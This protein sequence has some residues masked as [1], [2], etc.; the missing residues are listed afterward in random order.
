MTTRR[1]F[2]K[3]SALAMAGSLAA[4][5]LLL[6]LPKDLR[7]GGH[8]GVRIDLPEWPYGD[9][10]TATDTVLMFRGNP[11]HTFY[12][13]GPLRDT[14]EIAWRY[15]TER[16][17]TTLHDK[18]HVWTGPGWTGQAAVY[19]GHV[20]FGSVDRHLYC[21]D[22]A[23]GERR[24]RYRAA[25]MFK[26]SLCIY[27][28]RIYAVN[29]DDRIHCLDATTGE[30]VWAFDTGRDCDSSPC[31][32]DGKLYVAGESGYVRC[33][34]PDTGTEHWKVNVGG[35]GKGT[36]LGSN[37]A[38]S[39]VA[40]DGDQLF[41]GNYDGEFRCLSPK[42]GDQQWVFQTGDD[43]DVSAVIGPE[44]VY[45]AA[46]EASPHLFCLDRETGK[47]VWRFTNSSGWYS[48]PALVED[49]LYVGGNDKRMYCLDAKTG[50]KRW[51]FE[52]PASIWCSPAVVDGKVLFGS[53]GRFFHMLDAATGAEICQVNFG[54]RTHSAP[55][56]VNGRVYVGS[57]SGFFYCLQ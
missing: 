29:V 4:P 19:G 5:G 49:S 16:W 20:F 17:E 38:E 55:V 48:T 26:G 27:R 31:V 22:A 44:L 50:A 11:T 12:G 18:P 34:D 41:V 2:L 54:G 57:G 52:A 37:G 15:K 47:E 53:Y 56:V 10:S 14:L 25:R 33:L 28:N 42:N 46:E 32:Y 8:A 43:T 7:P 1:N 30:R 51:E 13:T 21:L 45:T 39:S 9:A 40:I 35:T 36:K 3:T 24:W 6:G 23:T